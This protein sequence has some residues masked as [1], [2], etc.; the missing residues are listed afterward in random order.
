MKPGKNTLTREFGPQEQ[1]LHEYGVD[2]FL[3]TF[4]VT[5][6]SLNQLGPQVQACN[7]VCHEA[8]RPDD[9]AAQQSE[10]RAF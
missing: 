6:L 9:D 8:Q 10:D 1:G 5:T 3:S 2:D 4:A 7:H